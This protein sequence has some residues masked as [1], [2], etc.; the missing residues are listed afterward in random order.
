MMKE[1]ILTGWN[2]MRVLY[3]ILGIV[4]IVQSIMQREWLGILLG[5]YLTSMGVFAFGCASGNCYGGTCDTTSQKSIN[6]TKEITDN[7]VK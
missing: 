3:L 7:D 1:R 5:L 4:V 2:Y 6:R